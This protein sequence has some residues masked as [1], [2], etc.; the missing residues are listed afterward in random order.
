[1]KYIT[2]PHLFLLAS[3]LGLLSGCVLPGVDS[4]PTAYPADYFPT[5]VVM[6]GRAAMATNL[7]GTPSATP[8]ETLP[9]TLTPTPTDTFTPIPTDTPT[10]SP[11][12]PIA[13]IQIHSPGPMSKV[14][15]PMLLRMQIVSGRS[16]LVQIDLQ[17]EDGR[18]LARNL[19]RVKRWPGGYIVSLKIPFEVRAVAEVGRITISTKDEVGRVQAQLG[20]RV[21]LLSVGTDEITPEGDSSERAVFYTP[22]KKDAVALDG[23]LAVNGRFLPYNDQ[24]VVLELIDVD[25]KT[26]GLRVLDDFIGT[27][28]QLFS[29]TIPYKVT[30]PTRTRLVLR[31]DDDRLAGLI[32]LYSQE[33]LLH[34]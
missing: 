33:I 12:A 11:S 27:E 28:E 2:L 30:D 34:P 10:P 29:T 18:L 19:E 21:L 31:Q 32:Y 7:A 22:S 3:L 26:V 20:M 8:T 25:G 23:V 16:E 1:M 4:A 24:Q 14:T 5:V 9:P 13:Q 15:S 17:G 6:T